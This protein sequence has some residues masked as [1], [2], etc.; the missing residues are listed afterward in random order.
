MLVLTQM[1]DPYE[2]IMNVCIWISNPRLSEEWKGEGKVWGMTSINSNK[3]V[4][5]SGSKGTVKGLTKRF[6]KAHAWEMIK[7][8]MP[9]F[10][11][12][13]LALLIHEIVLFPNVD[14]SVDHLVVEVFI[15]KNL[16]PFLL[17][18]F[19][20]IFHTRHENKGG[21]F[22]CCSPLLHLWMKV[23]VPLRGPF[24]QSNL[25]WP[26]KFA[27]FSTSSILWYKREWEIKD[28]IVIYGGFS[29]VP[30]IGTQGCINY[31]PILLKRQLGYAM[32]SPPEEK[33]FIPFF[34]NTMDPLN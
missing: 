3:L 31:N 1:H 24:S 6:L 29:N 30:L 15:T 2:W 32:L 9:D 10:C 8:E 34:V 17:V 11:S 28:V 12:A 18:D 23:Y 20:H 5:D 26:Q 7:E 21:T 4:A 22:L 27:P 19:Y 25:S 33:D 13:T 14:K 16:V